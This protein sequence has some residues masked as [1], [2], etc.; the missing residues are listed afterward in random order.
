MDIFSHFQQINLTSDQH[1]AL[2][3]LQLFLESET[4]VFILQGYAGSGKTTLLK[5]LIGYLNQL[6]KQFQ[7]MAPTGRAAKILR[8]KTGYGKTIHRGIYN[9]DELKTDSKDDDHTLH[10][11]FPVKNNDNIG[12]ILI[13][14]ESSMISSRESNNELF[15]FGTNI[16]LN[17]LMTYSQIPNS[18]TKIIFVGDPAQLPPVGD[19]ESKALEVEYFQKMGVKATSCVLKEVVRQSENL[20]LQNAFKFRSLIENKEINQIEFDFDNFSFEKINSQDITSKYV[21]LF[22]NPELEQSAIIAFSNAQSLEYNNAIRKEIFPNIKSVT[23]GDI[24]IVLNN[25]Y[26]LYHTELLNGLQIKVM[27]ASDNIISNKNIPVYETVNGKR[28]KK[29]ITLDFR[30]VT[31][32]LKDDDQEIKCL[33]IDS[34]LNSPYRDLTTLEFKALYIDFVMRFQEKQ[35][36]NKDKGL[37][38]YKVGSKEFKDELR[39]D[40]FY[41]AVRVKYGYAITCH[42]AQGGEWDIVFV[43]YFGRNSLKEDPLRWSYTATTR[44]VKKCYAANTPNVTKF[45]EFSVVKTQIVTNAPSNA[46]AID[47]IPLSPFHNETQAKCKSLKY[48]EISKKLLNT[49]FKIETV[50]SFGGY[51]ERYSISYDDEMGKFDVMHNGAG[52]FNDFSSS[53]NQKKEWHSELLEILNAPFSVIFNINYRPSSELLEQLYGLMNSIC[54][55]EGI[56]ITN[57]EEKTNNFF[58]NYYLKT[59]AKFA[60]IQFYFNK[61]NQLT[62]ALPKTMSDGRDDMLEN[63]LIKLNNHMN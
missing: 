45:T 49:S 5:G 21:A 30:E 32:R 55:D 39:T 17:D 60:M 48:W 35:K 36:L 42:K 51:Q 50:Q 11:Y 58:V 9:F 44:A 10:Y 8:E 40:P 63:L 19:S 12:E 1:N 27:E 3:K 14:D 23:S 34:L 33:I 38:F 7:V 15:T 41:N 62:R 37:P 52:L 57:I 6:R 56:T 20:L 43:D 25:N 61:K 28:I 31:V 53:N 4:Q 47:N 22:P 29:Y 54:S 13:I 16:L 26:Y 18:K 24:L 46:L 59:D 2:G